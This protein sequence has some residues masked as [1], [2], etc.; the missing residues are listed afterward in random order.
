MSNKN[1]GMFLEEV[2][3]RSLNYYAMNNIAFIEKK[4]VPFLITK[5]N[6]VKETNGGK[7]IQGYLFQKSTVDYIGM[8]RGKF[9]CF[10]AKSCKINRFDYKN[11]KEHQ[12]E[13]LNLIENNG[14]I[15]FLIFYFETE[16]VFLKTDPVWVY[17]D[18]IY[19]KSVS[20]EKLL[21]ISIKID[22]EFPGILNLLK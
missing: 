8:Y 20:L 16:N 15:A 1:K 6:S 11:I 10:E 3:N 13:Y 7:Q 19:N 22:L 21:K 17:N 2:I 9:I 4:T 12:I 14:G 18:M 5:V